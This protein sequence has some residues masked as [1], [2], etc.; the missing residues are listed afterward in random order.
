V[1]REAAEEKQLGGSLGTHSPSE[2]KG[3]GTGGKEGNS[4]F[5]EGLV[6]SRKTVI[7]PRNQVFVHGFLNLCNYGFYYP[8]K[9]LYSLVSSPVS[10]SE[11][12]AC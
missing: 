8:V 5:M 1:E 7:M 6:R 4:Q 10:W 12:S 2:S 9:A 3:A 11:T